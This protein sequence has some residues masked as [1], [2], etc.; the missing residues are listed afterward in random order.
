MV[1]ELMTGMDLRRHLEQVGRLGL[2][3]ARDVVVPIADALA[4][5]HARG[6][7][8]RDLKPENIFLAVAPSGATVPK[9]IDFGVSKIVDGSSPS[10]GVRTVSGAIVG[11]PRYMSPEQV[12]GDV[13]LDGRSDVWSLGVVLYELLAGVCPFEATN[14]NLA[15]LKI[16]TEEVRRIDAVADD[17]PPPVAAIVHGALE[18]RLE[19][20]TPSMRALVDALVGCRE[21]DAAPAAPRPSTPPAPP[22]AGRGSSAGRRRGTWC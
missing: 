4:A 12:R 9:L 15:M 13:A 14:P 1:Q 18:R 19:V 7:L 5:A 8:H 11:T 2:R 20:R 17:I 21:I 22:S 3:A 6:I 16:V 10:G